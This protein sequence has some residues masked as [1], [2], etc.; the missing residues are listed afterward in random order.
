MYSF[1][2]YANDLLVLKNYIYALI[3]KY[4][5]LKFFHNN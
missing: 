1:L 2:L 5:I 3:Y 4:S